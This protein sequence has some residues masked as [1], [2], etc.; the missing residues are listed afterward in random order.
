[1][2]LFCLE[3]ENQYNPLL[4]AYGDRQIQAS[5]S[6]ITSTIKR[7]KKTGNEEASLSILINGK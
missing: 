6:Q 5:D 7:K 4:R 2:T 3:L 1:M